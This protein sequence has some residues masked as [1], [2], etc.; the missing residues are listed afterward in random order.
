MHSIKFYKRQYEG[1][2]DF[3]EKYTKESRVQG[4]SYFLFKAVASLWRLTTLTVVCTP[5]H[6]QLHSPGSKHS[7]S[8][9]SFIMRR[10]HSNLYWQFVVFLGQQCFLKLYIN[11]IIFP[12][13]SR[14]VPARESLICDIPAGDGKNVNL[15]Y[16]VLFSNFS[17][18]NQYIETKVTIYNKYVCQLL[19]WVF[20]QL[21]AFSTRIWVNMKWCILYRY[22]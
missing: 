11:V 21:G 3:K 13:P 9:C 18:N 1:T 2:A 6:T 4:W 8:S 7:S 17:S 20:T 5:T 12:V 19:L 10:T 22:L 14:D 16:S 15:F